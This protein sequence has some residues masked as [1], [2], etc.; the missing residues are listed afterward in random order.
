MQHKSGFGY[1]TTYQAIFMAILIVHKL[2]NVHLFASVK[3]ID[4]TLGFP[5][6]YKR[7][8]I[9]SLR[10]TVPLFVFT[11]TNPQ[12]SPDPH[13]SRTVDIHVKV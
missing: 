6:S 7:M 11:L 8:D 10:I 13:G 12:W 3:N 2:R 4:T 9:L 5:I 1:T